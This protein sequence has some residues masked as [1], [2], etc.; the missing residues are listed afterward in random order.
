MGDYTIW[1]PETRRV[2]RSGT[3]SK[4]EL[5]VREGEMLLEGVALDDT[6]WQFDENDQPV[7]ISPSIP[8]DELLV[9]INRERQKRIEKGKDFNG[10]WLT[11]SDR[12]Q[13]ILMALGRKAEKLK[14][15]GI[16]DAVIPFRDGLNVVHLLTPDEMLELEDIGA[17]YVSAC[18][19]AAWALKDMAVIPQEVHADEHWP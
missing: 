15:A 4:P 10:I 18:Y 1:N 19:Q 12:D 9:M 16:N 7:E 8:Q 13:T 6:K 17:Q 2:L 14:N 3:S 5:Q 11:G